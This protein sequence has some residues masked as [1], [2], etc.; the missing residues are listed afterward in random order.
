LNFTNIEVS[1]ENLE[2]YKEN[3]CEEKNI[4]QSCSEQHMVK[5]D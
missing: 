3:I 4:I 5:Y 2:Q 1:G